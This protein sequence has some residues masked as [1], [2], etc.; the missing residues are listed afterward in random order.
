MHSI[1]LAELPTG[2]DAQ[3]PPLN[4]YLSY[5]YLLVWT[6]QV[7]VWRFS[8]SSDLTH[9]STLEDHWHVD[10]PWGPA[11]IIDHARGLLILPQPIRIGPPRLRIFT[12]RDGELVR[13]IEL[14]FGELA[15][16]DIHYRQADGH[17][18][19]L[20]VER[21]VP[22]HGKTSIVELDVLD[23]S[24]KFLS[25]VTLPPHLHERE[26]DRDLPPLVLQP[27]FFGKSVDLLYWQAEPGQ[28]DRQLTKT[29]ELLPAVEDCKA[30]LPVRHLALDDSTLVLC[31]HE[32]A[33]P[34]I[35]E[36]TSVRALD[37][38]TFTVRWTAQLIPGKVETLH[39]VPSLN[40]LV[41]RAEHDV[42]NHDED[43]ESLQYRTSVIV[44]DA[45]TGDRR[46][47]HAVDSDVQGSWIVDCFVSSDLDNPV[48][49]LAWQN[50]DVLTV[51][52]N[53]FIADGFEREGGG[54]RAQTLP[55]FPCGHHC[56][57]YG[58]QGDRHGGGSEEAPGHFA[59]RY[60]GGHS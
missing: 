29:L 46:A 24:T 11:P 18:L 26:K 10:K 53:K 30:M 20:L 41:L 12:L 56:C 42:T 4:F 32:D 27:I 48:V 38:S 9:V 43:R 59:G 5:P 3:G 31:T 16:V 28:D 60:R 57:F 22:P 1:A 50:G 13:D 37:T 39:H 17:M 35:T 51:D 23:P 25:L 58:T 33:G 34:A 15:D 40:V 7:D 6:D 44:L 8:D 55:A 49:G 14:S 52:L 47:I 21:A 2:P 19:V 45:R 36:Q 54:E